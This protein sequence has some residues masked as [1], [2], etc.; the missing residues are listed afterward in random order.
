MTPIGPGISRELTV[1]RAARIGDLRF[2]VDLDLPAEKNERIRGVVRYDF[3]LRDA[4]RPLSFDFLAA[5][6]NV[7]SVSNGEGEVAF[8]ARDD[9]VILPPDALDE[10]ANHVEIEFL[11]GDGSLN[12]S[13]DFLYTLFVPDRA[14][15]AFPCFDQPDL[16]ARI[17]LTLRT[18]EDWR[19]VSNGRAT[20]D[21]EGGRRVWRFAETEPLSTYLFAFAAGKF[22]VETAERDGRA[23]AFYHRETDAAKVARNRD[24]VFDLH[25]AALAW[26]EDY[27]G[28]AY[29]FSKFELVLLPGFQYGGME[30][31]GAVFYRDASLLLDASATQ[32]QILGRAS[33]ISHETA[34]MW[35]GDLVTMRWF[36]DVWMKE[37]FAN[38]YAAKIVNPSFPDVDHELRFLHA[39]YPGAYSVDRTAGTHPIRQPLADLR[40]AGALYGPI[41]YQKAPIVMRQLEDLI[42]PEAFRSGIRDYLDR[43]RFANADWHELIAVL[44]PRTGE[45]LASWSAAWVERGG[46]PT[47]VVEPGER[48]SIRQQDAAGRIWRQ[49]LETLVWRGGR[50]IRRS[51]ILDAEPVEILGDADFVLANG[52]G[53]GYGLFILDSISRDF[54]LERTPEIPDARLRGAAWLTLRENLYEGLVDPERLYALCLRAVPLEKDELNADA[55][56]DLA[57]ELLWTRI[58]AAERTERGAAL[59]RVCL[60]ELDDAATAA[61]RKARFFQTLVAGV[62]SPGGVARLREIWSGERAIEGLTLSEV[63]RTN[64]AFALALRLP[65]EADEILDR[66]AEHIENPDRRR[67]LDAVRPAASADPAVRDAYFAALAQAHNRR[68]EP[69]ALDG[70]LL[71]HHPLRAAESAKYV[72]PSLDLLDEIRAT[73]D[74]FFPGRWLGATLRLRSAPEDARA[75][76][77][78]LDERSDL[79]PDLRRQVLQAADGLLR[80]TAQG[81][82]GRRP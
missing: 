46:R 34:H 68:P 76:L 29:P 12:R 37:V 77:E 38:F 26:L 20:S 15:Y 80:L 65:E 10:G 19:A 62:L 67:R 36:D 51:L 18:P 45:D 25:A 11:A 48:R 22:Q 33:L 8:E 3:T 57:V 49:P 58:P 41:I 71:L 66:Q 17:S 60:R 74:I 75:T 2:A 79:S 6:D 63:D 5:P 55:V 69:W 32:A 23:L 21:V 43:Y 1:E 56:L 59:E 39:H 70:L 24:A 72:R 4:E 35:F 16:K 9:D 13:D 52:D 27:T 50:A 47:V 44:D 40:R 28:I 78:F 64:A 54:L 7:L 82:Y 61:T 31:P 81:Q 14:S 30:H 73:G 53:R 42:G